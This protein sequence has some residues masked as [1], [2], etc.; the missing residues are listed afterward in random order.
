MIAFYTAG[1]AARLTAMQMN[2]VIR[3][4]EDLP[5]KLVGTW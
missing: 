1:V 4:R 2:G 3:G 5:G